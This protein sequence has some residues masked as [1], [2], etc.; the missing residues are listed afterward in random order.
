M[1]AALV[2]LVRTPVYY[3]G[4]DRAVALENVALRQQFGSP[5]HGEASAL[6]HERSTLLGAARQGAAELASGLERRAARY[7][8]ALAHPMARA[9]LDPRLNPKTS[10]RPST[11]A[12]IRTLVDQMT[13]ANPLWGA[14]ASTGNWAS[15]A[16]PCR[17]DR[18][19]SCDDAGR[20]LPGKIRMRRDWS[21]PFGARVWTYRRCSTTTRGTSWRGRSGSR[22]VR[23]A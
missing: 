13:V 1:L 9:P 3:S 11:A 14:L 20:P 6:P 8:R 15:W 21:D 4:G 5:A 19:D 12:A 23:P 7:G 17:A 2:V 10:G 22:R 18:R 16:S